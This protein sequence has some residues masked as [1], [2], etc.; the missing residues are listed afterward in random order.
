MQHLLE[1]FGVSVAAIT[2][3]LAARGKQVDLFGVVVLALVTAFGGGTVRDVLLDCNPV[4][5]I[6]SPEYLFN[7][8]FTALL[9]FVVVRF[10][11]LPVTV[12]LVADAFALSLFTMVGALKA[13][14]FEVSPPITVIMGVVTGVVG[15][16]LRDVLLGQ[17]PLV[18][19][20]EIYLYATAAF[21]GATLFTFL[22]HWAVDLKLAMGAAITFTLCLRLLGIKLRL[23]LPLLRSREVSD[24]P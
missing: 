24:A 2:G 15:G 4:F 8:F 17:I 18:F 5:W 14:R 21:C 12:L 7:A 6:Q 3:V 11:E 16:M 22:V 20:R 1:H 13:L 19:R 10:R 9:T 23:S